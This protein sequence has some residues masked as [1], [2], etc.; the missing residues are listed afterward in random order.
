M[1]FIFTGLRHIYH[2]GCDSMISG[3]GDNSGVNSW[4]K[5]K[6]SLKQSNSVRSHKLSEVTVSLTVYDIYM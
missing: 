5:E 3:R 6:K 2:I 4:K 1:S